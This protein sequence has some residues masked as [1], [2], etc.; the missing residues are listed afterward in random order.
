MFFTKV[1]QEIF[2]KDYL[3]DNQIIHWLN[4]ITYHKTNF[5]IWQWHLFIFVKLPPKE[6]DIWTRIFKF[7]RISFEFNWKKIHWIWIWILKIELSHSTFNSFF[8]F[9]NS[10]FV[11]PSSI[12]FFELRYLNFFIKNSAKIKI[13]DSKLKLNW[14]WNLQIQLIQKK[15]NW[16]ELKSLNSMKFRII[17][18][19]LRSIY[20]FIVNAITFKSIAFNLSRLNRIHILFNKVQIQLNHI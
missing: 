3:Y 1:T 12:D 17:T 20:I 7:Y 8:S 14:N 19:N 5:H 18:S 2:S 13:V 10:K 11:I 4:R 16:I 6:I 9:K 15:L